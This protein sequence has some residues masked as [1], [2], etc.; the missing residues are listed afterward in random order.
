MCRDDGLDPQLMESG[1]R[2]VDYT[3]LLTN[4]L[5]ALPCTNEPPL[6]SS[7]LLSLVLSRLA[8]SSF[9]RLLPEATQFLIETEQFFRAI[10][11]EISKFEVD[12][13][14]FSAEQ[15]RSLRDL[16]VASPEEHRAWVEHAKVE[17]SSARGSLYGLL[18]DSTARVTGTQ[19]YCSLS[20]VHCI[21]TLRA[22][23]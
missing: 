17:G 14:E 23:V 5:T 13:T 18:C 20:T 3:R 9:Q 11:K 2:P 6:A 12:Q 4:V 7:Q 22:Q 8:S 10:A 15:I 19:V 1:D 16:R 21:P